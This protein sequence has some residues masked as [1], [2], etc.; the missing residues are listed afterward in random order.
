MVVWRLKYT[1]FSGDNFGGKSLMTDDSYTVRGA[2][3]PLSASI[4]TRFI[5]PRCSVYQS[6]EVMELIQA[7]NLKCQVKKTLFSSSS[8]R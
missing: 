7:Y 6:F 5:K 1:D 2:V 8:L 4:K 3:Q